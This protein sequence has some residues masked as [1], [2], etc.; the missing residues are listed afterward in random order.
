M[1]PHYPFRI[2]PA[3]EL[4]KLLSPV[5]EKSRAAILKRI[6]LA[7]SDR[8]TMLNCELGKD[9]TYITIDPDM[10]NHAKITCFIDPKSGLEIARVFIQSG[11]LKFEAYGNT[12]QLQFIDNLPLNEVILNNPHGRIILDADINVENVY[13]GAEVTE[14][15]VLGKLKTEKVLQLEASGLITV[16]PSSRLSA[17]YF[18]LR[19]DSLD[20]SGQ[21]HVLEGGQAVVNSQLQ[22]FDESQLT[23]DGWLYLH[24]GKLNNQSGTLHAKKSLSLES[25]GSVTVSGEGFLGCDSMLSLKAESLVTEDNAEINA[26]V[27]L[28]AEIA[29]KIVIGKDST[30]NV[31]EFDCAAKAL[32]NLSNNF[33]IG[34]AQIRVEADLINHPGA[35]IDIERNLRISG[36]SVWNQGEIYYGEALNARMNK[37]FVNGITDPDAIFSYIGNSKSRQQ[38]IGIVGGDMSVVAGIYADICSLTKVKRLTQSAFIKID[39][40]NVLVKSSQARSC[41][42]DLDHFNIELP[43]L[44][45]VLVSIY[46]ILEAGLSGDLDK[47]SQNLEACNALT[48]FARWI[49]R[50][51]AP[52]FG[53][54][55]DLGWS[56]MNALITMPGVL[57]QIYTLYQ[58]SESLA[59]IEIN[60]LITLITSTSSVAIQGVNIEGQIESLADS[61]TQSVSSSSLHLENAI[62]N[63]AAIFLPATVNNSILSVGSGL[64]T[65]FSVIERSLFCVSD[66][67]ISLNLNITHMFGTSLQG[68]LKLEMASTSSSIGRNLIDASTTVTE[69]RIVNATSHT[70]SGHTITTNLNEQTADFRSTA[71]SRTEAHNATIAGINLQLGGRYKT[72]TL[73]GHA[74]N[75]A[76]IAGV[77]ETEQANLNAGMILTHKAGS[78]V[79]GAFASRTSDLRESASTVATET[80]SNTEMHSVTQSGDN[81][82]LG[83]STR[84]NILKAEAK[85]EFSTSGTTSAHTANLHSNKSA[86]FGGTLEDM[87]DDPQDN[88]VPGILN[89]SAEE[90]IVT[91]NIHAEKSVVELLA[92]HDLD[93]SGMQQAIVHEYAG[94]NISDS[95]HSTSHEKIMQANVELLFSG[96]DYFPESMGG[97]ILELI[98]QR[99]TLAT[100]SDVSGEGTVVVKADTATL[101]NLAVANLA[102]MLDHIDNIQDLLATT[103]EY[104][105]IKLSNSL[106]VRVNE[107]VNL[108]RAMDFV[109]SV[110]VTAR[111]IFINNNMHSDH[112]IDL[113]STVGDIQLGKYTVSAHDFLRIFSQHNFIA[114]KSTLSGREVFVHAL[115]DIV[116]KAVLSVGQNY[117]QF[118]ADHDVRL[119][120]ITTAYHGQYDTMMHYDTTRLL[121]GAGVGHDGNGLLIQAGNKFY[122]AAAKLLT[123]GNNVILA[124]YGIEITALLHRYISYYREYSNWTGRHTVTTDY[125]FQLEHPVIYS[126]NGSNTLLSAE[127]YLR[128]VS[129]M[130]VAAEKTDI[131]CKAAI[132]LLGFI[133][134]NEEIKE[135]SGLFGIFSDNT[136]QRDDEAAPTEVVSQ[137]DITIISETSR[138]E[139]LNAYV[140]TLGLLSIHGVDVLISAPILNHFFSETKRGLTFSTPLQDILSSEPVF[141]D[142]KALS[143]SSGA[144]EYAANLWNTMIDSKN[145][146]TI[147]T[148]ASKFGPF[149]NLALSMLSAQ[150][151]Y[152]YSKTTMRYQAVANNV[153]LNA[154]NIDIKATRSATFA[155]GVKVDAEEKIHVTAPRII[156]KGADLDSSYENETASAGIGVSATG[157]PTGSAS[158]SESSQQSTSHQNQHL[159]SKVIIMDASEE[160]DMTNANL[161]GDDEVDI[162]APKEKIETQTG[163]SSSQ[164]SSGGGSSTGDFSLGHS[165]SKSETVGEASGVKTKIL[166]QNVGEKI[167]IGA[168]EKAEE[169]TGH[170]GHTTAS[171]VKEEKNSSGFGI[172]FN[173]NDFRQTTPPGNDPVRTA[174]VHIDQETY[175]GTQ[176]ASSQ[177]KSGPNPTA[178]NTSGYL[179]TQSDGHKTTKDEHINLTVKVPVDLAKQILPTAPE[180]QKPLPKRSSDNVSADKEETKPQSEPKKAPGKKHPLPSED[181]NEGKTAPRRR[182]SIPGDGPTGAGSSDK[183][184]TNPQHKAK[185]PYSNLDDESAAKKWSKIIF[186]NSSKNTETKINKDEVVEKPSDKSNPPVVNI[187]WL[188]AAEK[189]NEETRDT[190]I[191]VFAITRDI[192]TRLFSRSFGDTEDNFRNPY[193]YTYDDAH[194]KTTGELRK[195]A[196]ADGLNSI[197]DMAEAVPFL[198]VPVIQYGAGLKILLSFDEFRKNVNQLFMGEEQQTLVH[199]GAVNVGLDG[200]KA[201]YDVATFNFVTSLSGLLHGGSMLTKFSIFQNGA[202]VYNGPPNNDSKEHDKNNPSIPYAGPDIER[203]PGN[204]TTSRRAG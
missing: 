160:L 67:E 97:H 8:F 63:V 71:G 179:D 72:Q 150:I 120:C 192:S 110:G 144:T 143:S 204:Y 90:L 53:K 52:Q 125:S 25:S 76:L 12:I 51:A 188:K 164:S 191:L 156:L 39:L 158:A 20:F 101:R 126:T 142:M 89:V 31:A 98:A 189:Y 36:G 99:V 154:G 88:P 5:S 42:I 19:S 6:Q 171:G 153:G 193:S 169:S 21:L 109:Y 187:S 107:D 146:A 111:Q 28:K 15:H 74:K 177:V 68:R 176:E 58:T 85:E 94:H 203:D 165:A 163:S 40:A 73:S 16:D 136:D 2:L 181:V 148:A 24:V 78:Y 80:G 33:F 183:D 48:S 128:A 104:A 3:L 10:L 26:G 30:W 106:D 34:D 55:V 127:G 132:Q 129:A 134:N 185:T 29:D 65:G 115:I 13:I 44:K 18:N 117:Q 201:D 103:G 57:S 41:L 182:K 108:T 172:S 184:T 194:P 147:L 152:A 130:F 1:A 131:G 46:D 195:D 27:K 114:D 87:P 64:H 139:L 47:I 38:T 54:V 61:I 91:A 116:L 162:N 95:A 96:A 23:S 70:E 161:E 186:S 197:K 9:V 145:F 56:L 167:L 82:S 105:S 135:K 173:V 60:K 122:D 7:V 121:S 75:N 198:A 84:A 175:R 17:K 93:V 180:S 69:T 45:A 124:R 123:M 79:H 37:Y 140:Y 133:L 166:R 50:L 149:G 151:G 141:Q 100:S 77:V 83:G 199:Q 66:A 178:A 92:Q 155:N 138:V 11:K 196:A 168:K 43:N 159:H 4:E 22:A 49:L 59:E 102:V 157:A 14:L 32:D 118:V 81:I 170:V 62:T 86:H 174:T 113:T 137:S 190:M 202:K 119:E 112:D 35:V 200:D